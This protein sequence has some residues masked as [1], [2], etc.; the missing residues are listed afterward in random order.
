MVAQKADCS[1]GQSGISLC[2]H[3]KLSLE[4]GAGI[5]TCPHSHETQDDFTALA[6][7]PST[8]DSWA[9]TTYEGLWVGSLW[10]FTTVPPQVYWTQ[11]WQRGSLGVHPC[12]HP[13]WSSNSPGGACLLPLWGNRCYAKPTGPLINIFLTSDRRGDV[14]LFLAYL[15]LCQTKERHSLE[16]CDYSFH[17]IHGPF[18]YCPC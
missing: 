16:E 11:G 10:V 2:N 8:T 9:W 13:G 15:K 1:H 7:W 17:S 18:V 5:L 14:L 4:K 12:Q 3:V 6:S